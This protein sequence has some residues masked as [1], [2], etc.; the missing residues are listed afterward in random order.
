MF[1]LP[2]GQVQVDVRAEGGRASR[3]VLISPDGTTEVDLVV[4]PYD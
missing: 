3:E 2:A 1:D 4:K